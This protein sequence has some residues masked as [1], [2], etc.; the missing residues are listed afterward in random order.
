M[1]R[2]VLHTDKCPNCGAYYDFH[3]DEDMAKCKGCGINT[4]I[5]RLDE[6]YNCRK[7][8][9]YCRKH[10]CDPE[11]LTDAELKRFERKVTT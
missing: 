4:G 10:Y 6:K 7:L 5:F 2:M 3:K 9:R 8:M 11:D 1:I